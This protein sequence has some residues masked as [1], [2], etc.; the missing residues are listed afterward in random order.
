M[1]SMGKNE[2]PLG[3]FESFEANGT[4][5][6]REKLSP[7]AL[8]DREDDFWGFSNENSKDICETNVKIGAWMDSLKVCNEKMEYFNFERSDNEQKRSILVRHNFRDCNSPKMDEN[9]NKQLLIDIPLSPESQ[10]KNELCSYLQ[11]MNMNNTDKKTVSAIQNRR[12]NRVKNLKI[13]SEKKRMEQNLLEEFKESLEKKSFVELGLDVKES[14]D[15]S[16]RFQFKI[17]A[18]PDDVLRKIQDFDEIIIDVY[19]RDIKERLEN[20]NKNNN[21][22]KKRLLKKNKKKDVKINQKYRKSLRSCINLN[23]VTIKSLALKE[24]IKKIKSLR[25]CV[26]LN[27]VGIKSLT[28]N[29]RKIRDI[30][31]KKLEKLIRFNKKEVRKIK[32][33]REIKM[34]KERIN[35]NKKIK[36][37]V[38]I[39]KD[40]NVEPKIRM[41]KDILIE[42][43][44]PKIIIQKQQILAQPNDT[45]E[46]CEPR[47][48]YS[49]KTARLLMISRLSKDLKNSFDIDD[50]IT[51]KNGAE[52]NEKIEYK[53]VQRSLSFN[54][55]KTPKKRRKISCSIEPYIPDSTQNLDESISSISPASLK[56]LSFKPEKLNKQTPPKNSFN[57]IDLSQNSYNCWEEHNYMKLSP[58]DE[59]FNKEFL[60]NESS[61]SSELST[62]VVSY[63]EIPVIL[64][65]K[66][67]SNKN[68]NTDDCFDISNSIR[69]D[70]AKGKVLGAHYIGYNLVLVQEQLVSFWTQS[71]LGNMLGAQ[72]LWVSKG[73]VQRLPLDNNYTKC[74][75]SRQVVVNF[76][77]KSCAYIELWTKEH[78]SEKREL[79]LADV[80][81]TVYFWTNSQ[82]ELNKKLLQ[83]ANI[84][85]NIEDVQYVVLRNSRKIIVSWV[86][87]HSPSSLTTTITCYTLSPDYQA[88]LNVL[89]MTSVNHYIRSLHTMGDYGNFVVGFGENILIL[90]ELEYGEVFETVEINQKYANPKLLWL[91]RDRGLLFFVQ[92]HSFQRILMLVAVNGYSKESKRLQVFRI[93]IGYDELKGLCVD[94]NMLGAVFENGLICWNIKTGDEII[95]ELSSHSNL[96]PSNK[97]VIEIRSDVVEVSHFQSYFLTNFDLQT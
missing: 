41:D 7:E 3:V 90:W 66:I 17:D 51:K 48:L 2:F 33:K 55:D 91:E 21:N 57:I 54:Q 34:N 10:K 6:H 50:E 81:A 8:D 47:K 39:I 52:L 45:K 86:E 31:R 58:E 14:F 65:Q 76:D 4:L 24:K 13:M 60:L 79:P 80:F 96:M 36:K 85:G 46:I 11:L 38:K 77:N 28:L 43:D 84:K 20:E 42:N 30:K 75:E 56:K 70:Y 64:E 89:E 94:N 78:K 87:N 29:E 16:E 95:A 61:S 35:N 9:L 82:Q 1:E 92:Y 32:K 83:L 74:K 59:H 26:N 5:F 49:P 53:K 72:N 37:K 88:V 22:V 44:S 23:D 19:G 63:K 18:I 69:I 97:H 12:S 62:D 71:P 25:S 68:E 93:P 15:L 73:S 27:N 67:N 40:E